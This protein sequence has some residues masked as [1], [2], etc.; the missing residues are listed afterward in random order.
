[1]NREL[2]APFVYF[3]EIRTRG[4]LMEHKQ[5][6]GAISEYI[7]SHIDE[8][9]QSLRGL[10]Q[11]PSVAEINKD[12]LPFGQQSAEAL[13]YI[14]KLSESFGLKT[15]NFENYVVTA[16]C[17]EGEP[18]LGILAH[19]DVVPQGEGWT[20]PC[21][22][23]TRDGGL[24]YG[25]GAIDDKGPAVAALYAI[26]AINEL[27]I[28]LS[29]SVRYIFG[30]GEELGCDD[31]VYYAEHAKLPQY[32]ITPDGEFPIVNSEKGMI[33]AFAKKK[34]M[35]SKLIALSCRGAV[36]A[37][38]AKAS[39]SVSGFAREELLGAIG[40]RNISFENHDGSTV[41]TSVGKAAHGSRPEQGVNALTALLEVLKALGIPEAAELSELF[42]FRE[43]N[44]KQFGVDFRDDVSGELTLALTV[45]EMTDTDIEIGVDCRFPI[46][47]KAED[48]MS[49]VEPKLT[50]LGY[51]FTEKQSM[52]PHYVPENTPFIA[53]LKRA[54]ETVTGEEAV[55]ICETG[56]TYAHSTEH[57]VAFGAQMHGEE[58]NM[59]SADENI[60]VELLKTIAKVYAQAIIELCS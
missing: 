8:M 10:M 1:M 53:A 46:S 20:K 29:K 42:P 48:V 22:D 7:E 9:L 40:D 38:P 56:V 6:A 30:G 31:I 16:D 34:R 25:R 24:V 28:P 32:I 41:L 35:P 52:E 14:K 4:H 5:Y 15:E 33:H 57:G 39:A 12:G 49:R 60:S 27:N 44:G 13:R 36:N 11:V 45:C 23:M 17:G 2:I 18:V 43:T 54:Y 21:F 55:C 47:K 3:I 58:N 50:S 51:E 59:H 37:I 26:K 19:V